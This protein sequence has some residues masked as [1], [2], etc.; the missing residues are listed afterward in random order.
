MRLKQVH[1][2]FAGTM[3]QVK[4]AKLVIGLSLL[5]IIMSFTTV[6]NF[7]SVAVAQTAPTKLCSAVVPGNYRDSISVPSTW[8]P[9]QCRR[10]ASSV[11]ASIYQLGCIFERSFSWGGLN[12]TPPPSN[13]C[14]W[15][16]E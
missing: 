8:T 6:L 3:Q 12:G 7:S 2:S 1:S 10:Y 11:G 5:I 15:F 4:K 13:T 14:G 16:R 9:D